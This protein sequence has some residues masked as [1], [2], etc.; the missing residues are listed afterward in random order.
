MSEVLIAFLE[1]YSEHWTNEEQ[2]RKLLSVA[3]IAWNAAVASGKKGEEL[4]QSTLQA[5]PPEVR[6]D[7][8]A[9]I[10]ELMQRK[11]AHFAD[12]KRLIISYELTMAPSG[13]RI[14][15]LSTLDTA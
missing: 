2:L 11:L 9:I 13:P 6:G 10:E 7:L 8:K 12:N 1:P 3:L 14:S 15:V 4:I 5:A